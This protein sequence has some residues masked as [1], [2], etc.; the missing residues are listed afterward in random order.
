MVA[1]RLPCQEMHR[2]LSRVP[3]ASLHAL[4]L[5][6]PSPLFAVPTPRC[7]YHPLSQP[8]G[9]LSL[10]PSRGPDIPT[11]CLFEVV[12]AQNA[13]IPFDLSMAPS[14][15]ASFVRALQ[16][17]GRMHVERVLTSFDAR[18]AQAAIAADREQIFALI[19]HSYG[20]QTGTTQ[21]SSPQANSPQA[22]S[23]RLCMGCG[24]HSRLRG[25]GRGNEAAA[26]PKDAVIPMNRGSWQVLDMEQDDAT[27]HAAFDAFNAAVRLAIKGALGGLS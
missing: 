8:L 15:R 18:N 11:D 27:V 7:P 22:G 26:D 13:G 12:H 17:D 21:G 3:H 5:F 25:A 14:E 4:C 24:M 2:L 9:M 10:P 19:V 23:S 16:R 6:N 1:A 20:R